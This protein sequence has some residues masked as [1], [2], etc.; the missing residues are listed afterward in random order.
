M[1]ISSPFDDS[2]HHGWTA[3][4]ADLIVGQIHGGSALETQGD[5]QIFW[6]DSGDQTRMFQDIA[7]EGDVTVERNDVSTGFI[8]R[9][10]RQTQNSAC[11]GYYACVRK[12]GAV[13][14]IVQLYRFPEFALLQEARIKGAVEVNRAGGLW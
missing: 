7:I 5:S 6:G 4:G 2:K 10:A 11:S 13:F 8:L 1:L 3:Y 14:G 12:L 9:A